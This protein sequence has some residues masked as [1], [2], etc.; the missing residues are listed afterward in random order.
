MEQTHVG[1]RSRQPLPRKLQIPRIDI[2]PH[3]RIR[4]VLWIKDKH[5]IFPEQ[6]V[7]GGDIPAMDLQD[8]I[9]L[10]RVAKMLMPATAYSS[11]MRPVSVSPLDD[12]DQSHR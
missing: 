2:Q 11:R 12:D 8:L 7:P 5:W 4:L 9:A 10:Q 1:G 6:Q 3:R